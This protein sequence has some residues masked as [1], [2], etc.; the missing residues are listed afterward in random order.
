MMLNLYTKGSLPISIIL[1]F[2]NIDPE[3]VKRQLEDDLY[4]VND[5]KFNN[6]LDNVYGNMG[7]TILER[8]DILKRVAKGLQLDE[9]Q[10]EE[11]GMEGTGDGV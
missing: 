6:L 3:T 4:T 9:I 10:K 11:V 5:S 2:L 7:Q 1:E 8:T